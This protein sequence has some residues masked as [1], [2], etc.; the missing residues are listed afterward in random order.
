MVRTAR[1]TLAVM[2]MAS[3]A[4]VACTTQ[5]PYTREDQTSRATQGAV[6]GAL[7]GAI[8]GALTNTSSG[9]QAA[10]NALIGAGVGALAGG[11]VGGYQDRQEAKLRERLDQ[12]GVGIRRI[13]DEIELVMPGDITFATNQA[14]ITSNFYPVLDDVALVLQEFDKTYIQ[15]LGHTDRT[16]TREYNQRL[17]QERANSVGS[18]MISRGLMPERLIVQG[19]GEDRPVVPTADG[20]AE[21]ANRRVEIRISPLT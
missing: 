2:V 14:A 21:R 4:L 18:Y 17:S 8:V 9:K 11:A 10:R 20:V 12:T 6:I 16:G 7:G 13:G 3:F 5:D 15:V 1:K 19:Y